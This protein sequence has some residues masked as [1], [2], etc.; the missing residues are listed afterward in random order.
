MSQ[1]MIEVSNLSRSF[2]GS[3]VL[4]GVS[5]TAPEGSITALLGPNGAGK[6]TLV[7]ILS[8]VIRPDGGQARIAGMDV[9]SDPAGIRGVISLTGQYAAVDELLTGE[10]NMRLTAQL[11]RV[12]ATDTSARISRLLEEFDLSD[13]SQRQVKT[14]SGGM[15][16]KLDLAMSLLGRPKVL[17][18]DEPTT[19][20]DPSSRIALWNIVRELAADGMTILLT[21]QYLEEADKLA[22]MVLM[23]HNG[24]I[25]ESG[26][27][28]QLKSQLAG[29][30]LAVKVAEHDVTNARNLINSLQ[31]EQSQ[32]DSTTL[33]IA[34]DSSARQLHRI[35]GAL[36]ESSIAVEETSLMPPTLDDV[37]LNLVNN[38][39]TERKVS[40]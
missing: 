17:I 15:R 14:W 7:R 21:T 27:P 8:T 16:R 25:V 30:T 33:S 20:L 31:I 5:F 19:G 34:T 18:L 39:S 38:Q 40:V 24:Q 26:T 28:K 10:E 22:H 12:P 3:K 29:S 2:G 4:N 6:T 13:A 23:L 9:E 37:F 32:L 35:L 11:W 1:P 36:L